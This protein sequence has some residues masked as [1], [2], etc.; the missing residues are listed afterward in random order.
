MTTVNNQVHTY[1]AMSSSNVSL[2]LT[3]KFYSMKDSHVIMEN[4]MMNTMVHQ[5]LQAIHKLKQFLSV[6]TAHSNYRPFVVSTYICN[7]VCM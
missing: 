1:V 4:W 2:Y 7:Y 5:I 3:F 6:V